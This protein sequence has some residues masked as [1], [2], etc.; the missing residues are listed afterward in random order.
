MRDYLLK[1]PIFFVNFYH[2]LF[3][4]PCIKTVKRLYL[5]V[6]F[7]ILNDNSTQ[8]FRGSLQIAEHFVGTAHPPDKSGYSQSASLLAYQKEFALLLIQASPHPLL[9]APRN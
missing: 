6:F 3:L 2:P 8:L 1:I 9:I 7:T 4:F 5:R